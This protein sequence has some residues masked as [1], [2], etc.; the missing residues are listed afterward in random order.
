MI[1]A[2]F[3]SSAP[4]W[5]WWRQ[6]PAED[7]VWDGVQFV[8]GG[9]LVG[10]DCCFVF[11][12]LPQAIAVPL[13]RSRLIFVA[14]EPQNVK[15]YNA[16]FLDQFGTVLTTDRDTAHGGRRFTQVGLPW[17][18]GA[19]SADGSLLAEPLTLRDFE[20]FRPD[21]TK[22]VSVVSSNK[23]FT[24]E[25]RARLRFVDKLKEH[26]GD[27]VDV[28]GRGINDFG[29]KLQVLAPYRYHIALENC[30]IDDYWTEKLADPFLTLTY[31][32]YHGCRNVGEYFPDGSFTAIDIYDP[33]RAI[34]TIKRVIQSDEAERTQPLLEEA[35]RR[36]LYEHNLFALLARVAREVV[37]RPEADRIAETIYAEDRFRP[38]IIR[39]RTKLSARL[40]R[41]PRVHRLA[42]SAKICVKSCV[43][44]SKH[45]VR[46]LRDIHY[47]SHQ[48]W[49]RNEPDER[50]R[51]VYPLTESSLVFDVGG[52]RG[53]YSAKIVS[54]YGSRVVIFEPIASFA[55][56][57]RDRFD[58]DPRVTL[59]EAALADANGTA[60]FQVE[61]DASGAYA[62]G[63]KVDVQLIDAA[64][65]IEDHHIEQIDLAKFNIEGG[66]YA[67]L[68]YLIASGNIGRFQNLQIQFH[69]NVPN[70]QKR[71]RML[72]RS[73]RRT[74]QLEWRFPFVWES[75]RRKASI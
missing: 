4:E 74:H 12:A 64:Q 32:I 11:D 3:V 15:R 68:E 40:S 72:A 19:W 71:Y 73:L 9:D 21:K 42:R 20:T 10:C 61:G 36:V 47:R 58:G 50:R 62:A 35:R 8:F 59:V 45:I 41:M 48:S 55:K 7:L 25:H 38:L 6:F 13:D 70:A 23:A 51:Y 16:A 18:V 44:H 53:D 17:H 26:F 24:E 49:L 29:D 22:L 1:K 33:A 27:Q 67:L 31:P 65:F 34:E 39:I 14:S 57:I 75:W 66:E 43:D 56:T 52:F 63:A 5:A 46:L 54:E 37:G 60:K 30:A 2:G 28:F 69:L